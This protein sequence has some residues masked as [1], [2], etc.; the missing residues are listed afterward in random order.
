MGPPDATRATLD[1]SAVLRA[2]RDQL[3]DHGA[4]SLRRLAARLGVTAP[5]LYAYF[6]SKEDLLRAVAD[7][8]FNRLASRLER[9]E[10][11]D[12]VE[13][14][15]AR[16]HAYVDHALEHPALFRVM[17]LFRPDWVG[18]TKGDELLAASRAFAVAAVPVQQA[19]D[20]GRL[21]G[22]DALLASL[23]IWSA[24]HGVATVLLAGPGLPEAYERALVD[25]VIDSVLAGLAP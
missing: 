4:V 5:A 12:P 8:E 11:D 21:R 24:V 19:I 10:E 15:R 25:S 2:A 14:I 18:S 7:E 20:D 13:L 6:P 9:V 3:V 22:E 1:R 17:F 16:S 23:T